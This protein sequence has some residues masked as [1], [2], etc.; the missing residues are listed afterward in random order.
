M[1]VATV[2]RVTKIEGV[3]QRRQTVS[4]VESCHQ[5]HVRVADVTPSQARRRAMVV[6]P[7]VF[8]WNR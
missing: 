6:S 2:Q 7:L 8:R 3:A 5:A 4:V 1:S